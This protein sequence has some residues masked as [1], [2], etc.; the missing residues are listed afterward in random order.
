MTEIRVKHLRFTR[1]EAESFLNQEVGE[2]FTQ[3]EVAVLEERTEG[4]IAGLQIAALSMQ[5][6]EDI[7]GFVQVFSGGHRHILG[8]LADEVLN[9]RPK[10]TLN[11]LL[12]TAILDRLCGPLCDAVTE[13]SNGQE[14]LESLEHANLFI[15]PLDNDCR[16][17]R[18]H[19]LFAEVL[20]AQ[21]KQSQGNQIPDLHQRASG[22]L[23]QNGLI[24]E[25]VGHSFAAQDF[26]NAARL[27]ET[28]AMAQFG[29]PVIQHSLKTWL[30]ALPEKA[31]NSRPLMFLVHAWQSFVQLDMPAASRHVDVAEQVLQQIR[32]ELEEDRNR[33]LTGSIAAM[34][35]LTNAFKPAPD[36]DQVLAS[37]DVA[38]ADLD[39]D[40]F[41]FRGFAA[42]AAGSAYLKRGELVQAERMFTEAV[43]NGRAAGNIYMLGASTDNLTQVMRV[44]GN[45]HQAIALCREI[46]EGISENREKTFPPTGMIYYSLA[47]LLREMNGLEE[48]RHYAE[49]SIILTDSSVNPGHTIFSHFV[50]A[51]IKQAQQ[52]WDGALEDLAKVS[53]WMQQQPGMWNLDIIPSAEAQL[54][55]MREDLEQAFQ[56]AMATGWPEDPW[57][58]FSTTWELIWQHEHLQIARAQIFI[59]YGQKTGNHKLIQEAEAYLNRQQVLAEENGLEWYRIKLLILRSLCR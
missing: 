23:E 33:N 58:Q 29:Q 6:H 2:R 52:D 49:E 40:E 46:L 31:T 38:L 43:E 45:W 17:Y 42:G 36:L 10:G 8:Y 44:Q 25:A 20:R 35:A 11:F 22:W 34:R 41:N 3:E 27:I 5:G 47:D 32:F 53:S 24:P 54:Q 37:A 16:W 14:I 28:V 55:A 15:M 13:G 50:L 57:G 59:A 48:A 51:H 1:V 7:S 18:Y 39:P 12:Q 26:E 4:W 30:A 56:W 9:Q 21:L 19:H